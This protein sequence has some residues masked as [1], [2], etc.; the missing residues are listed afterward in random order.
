[1][2]FIQRDSLKRDLHFV[3]VVFANS[4][5]YFFILLSLTLRIRFSIL[6]CGH[7][8]HRSVCN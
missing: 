3:V 6:I 1:M 4:R 5:Y 2:N 7:I 8:T